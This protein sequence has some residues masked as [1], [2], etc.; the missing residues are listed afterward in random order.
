MKKN[1]NIKKREKVNLCKKNIVF[2]KYLNSLNKK[3]KNKYIKKISTKNELNTIIEL[4]INFLNNN[5]K[6]KRQF[7]ISIKKYKNHFYKIIKKSNSLHKKKKLLSGKVGG[8]LLQSILALA[9]PFLTK[10]FMK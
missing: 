7:L 4:F 5:I 9:I 3:Q 2:L 8:F 1:R 6:C 10:M